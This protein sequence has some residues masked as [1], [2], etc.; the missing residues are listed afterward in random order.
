VIN[1][2]KFYCSLVFGLGGM[3]GFGAFCFWAAWSAAH[4]V[5]FAEAKK[6]FYTVIFAALFFYAMRAVR[7][8][9]RFYEA[10]AD[11][12]KADTLKSKRGGAR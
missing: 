9:A 10:K 3:L 6:F 2:L 5:T 4:A 12:L 7:A 8:V 1:K 11:T